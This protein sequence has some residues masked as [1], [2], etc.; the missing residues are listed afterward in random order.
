MVNNRI[1]CSIA[2]WVLIMSGSGWTFAQK[3]IYV[4]PNGSDSSSGL[5]AAHPLRTLQAAIPLATPGDE[6]RLLPGTY[7]GRVSISGLHGSPEKPVTFTSD[8][9]DTSQFAVIDG[10]SAPGSG[11]QVFA[12]SISSSS[13]LVFR[14][15]K[16]R[17][18]WTDVMPISGSQYI[19]VIGCDVLGGRRVVYPQSGS[20]H[21][22]VENCRW[23]QDERVWTT[24]DWTAMHDGA[25]SYYNG[26]LFA[27]MGG[28]GSY[29]MRGNTI[30]NV[31][32]GVRPKPSV[33]NEDGNIEIYNNSFMNVA[34]NAFE[35]E[36][37]AWNVHFYHNQIYN[38]H[39]AFS[40][41]G[42]QGG[43]IYVYGNTYWQSKDSNAID[44][45][46]GIWKFKTGP[47]TYPCYAF[48]N[49]FYTEA[50]AFKS[51]EATNKQMKH[52]NNA[53]FFFQGS[54]RMGLYDWDST[55]EFDNDCIN[56]AW[57]VNITS[58]NQETNG[59]Q[60]TNAQ[61]VNGAAG[62][63]HLQSGSPCIE[64]GKIISFPEFDW[65]Q[66]VKGTAPSIGAFDG[67]RLTEGPPF[68]FRE[69]PGGSG[70][71][72]KPRIV[73]HRIQGDTLLI[74]FSD[75]I[76][77]AAMSPASVQVYLDH[78]RVGVEQATFPRNAYELMVVADRVLQHDKLALRFDPLPVGVNGESATHWAS[79]IPLPDD[80]QT[81][82]GVRG[83]SRGAMVNL[84]RVFP[85]P[86]NSRAQI[87]YA[88]SLSGRTTIKVYDLLGRELAVLVDGWQNV[89][90]HRTTLD[91]A[92]YGSGVYFLRLAGESGISVS[93]FLI[94]K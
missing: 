66:E 9:A 6:I 82:S 37:W 33:W 63:F 88:L 87:E 47:L 5:D 30:R 69:P 80:Q 73:R 15:L 2:L 89:G 46:S 27:P 20:H 83:E 58:H 93:R 50:Q 18:C 52:F 17:N 70:T 12:F 90:T 40:I 10:G 41:D 51:G 14:N 22:L 71:K 16:V 26:A 75:S 72:E 42:V 67:D 56:Q 48:N 21:I 1:C 54:N 55:F 4:S 53:Y 13:W 35:P 3:N 57:P 84:L 92:R 38:N 44:K 94:T 74:Y 60:N 68:R 49:S 31:F 43:P 32:N 28:G 65:R 34:D 62:D 64:K 59:L 11:L 39:K 19:S 78:A 91:M 24:F 23:E 45:V 36:Q 8:S 79:T 86:F 61:F 77:V 25:L 85:N 29:V 7:P 76:N 81:P